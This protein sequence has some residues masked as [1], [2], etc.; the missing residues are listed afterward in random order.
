MEEP[1]SSLYT[2]HCQLANPQRSEWSKLLS[3]GC[4]VWLEIFVQR[5]PWPFHWLSNRVLAAAWCR[6]LWIYDRLAV[7]F[8]IPLLLKWRAN[9]MICCPRKGAD[10]SRP[11]HK[12]RINRVKRKPVKNLLRYTRE[13][14]CLNP[15]M[16]FFKGSSNQNLWHVFDLTASMRII[17]WTVDIYVSVFPSTMRKRCKDLIVYAFEVILSLY[18]QR[19]QAFLDCLAW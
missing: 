16:V 14:I 7:Y 6:L 9:V 17:I 19:C 15:N 10:H 4:W 1:I 2:F 8:H 5:S 13:P 3:A 18:F 11:P 12:S